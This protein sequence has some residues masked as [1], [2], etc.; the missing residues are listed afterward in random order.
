M[1]VGG[2]YVTWEIILMCKKF[3]IAG[4]CSS[5]SGQEVRYSHGSGGLVAP[6]HAAMLAEC[7]VGAPVNQRLVG[8]VV[9][10]EHA[11]FELALVL[12]NCLERTKKQ[13]VSFFQ[14]H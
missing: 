12:E 9:V 8:V 3:V 2:I 6:L 4:L 5:Y 1:F 10:R 11:L 7:Y 13:T 14:E